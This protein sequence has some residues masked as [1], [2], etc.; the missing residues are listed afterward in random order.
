MNTAETV[1]VILPSVLVCFQV[2]PV[3]TDVPA[4]VW[5]DAVFEY[6]VADGKDVEVVFL[7]CLYHIAG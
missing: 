4:D 5:K 7:L 2:F 1:V 6:Q 3:R